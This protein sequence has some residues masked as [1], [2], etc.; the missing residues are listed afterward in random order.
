L[1]NDVAALLVQ[2]IHHR[3]RNQVRQPALKRRH[4]GEIVREC[5]HVAAHQVDQQ[6]FAKDQRA[7]RAACQVA[8]CAPPRI[9]VG[10]VNRMKGDR[11]R[12]TRGGKNVGLV[13]EYV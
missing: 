1:A 4:R 5:V 2:Q 9:R 13:V 8:E 10:Q 6:A 3:R 12:R 7:C 11:A